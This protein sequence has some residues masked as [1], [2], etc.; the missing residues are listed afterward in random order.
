ME[1]VLLGHDWKSVEPLFWEQPEITAQTFYLFV[2]VVTEGGVEE[3]MGSP[4]KKI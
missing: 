3:E 4:L 2:V 1:T